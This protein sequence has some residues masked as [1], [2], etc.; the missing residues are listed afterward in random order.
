MAALEWALHHAC[1]EIF[2]SD[3]GS[4]FTSEAF[5]SRLESTGVL[6]SMDG[7]GRVTDN[8]FVERLWRRVKYEEVY[9]KD[10]ASVPE[11][12]DNLRAYFLFY[13]QERSHQALGYQTPAAVYLAGERRRQGHCRRSDFH[14]VGWVASPMMMPP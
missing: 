4:Q 5:T 11:A 7:Q 6:I 9:L 3:Q 13:D 12:V 1:P 8:I 10:Y 14:R 2:N